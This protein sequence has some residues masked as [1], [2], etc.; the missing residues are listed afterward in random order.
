MSDSLR[1]AKPSRGSAVDVS[2]SGSVPGFRASERG[3]RFTNSFP[4]EPDVTLD[5]GPLGHVG[6]GNASQGVC[7]GM[8]FA[9]RDYFE[10]GLPVPTI[11]DPPAKGSPL[12]DYVVRRLLESF[13]VPAGIARYAMWM[14]LPSADIDVLM[15]HEHGTSHRTVTETWPAVKSDIDAGH[16]SPLGLVPLHTTDI[17]RIG[18][19]HQVLAYAYAVD[20]ANTLTLSIYDPNTST[21]DADGV[22]IRLPLGDAG[23]S[24]VINHN[25]NIAESTLHGFFRAAYSPRQPPQIP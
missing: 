2:S 16:P 6:I 15:V 17:S 9:V 20:D 5:L 7:G 8:A 1:H 22:W 18:A 11:A 21:A 24:V 25:V 3:F 23:H 10:A 4:P 14:A 19:C 13:D 12:F